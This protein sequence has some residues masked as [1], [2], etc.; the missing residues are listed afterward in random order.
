MNRRVSRKRVIQ[1]NEE[2]LLN[3]CEAHLHFLVDATR[4]Y[5]EG[6][7]HRFK[8]IAAELRVLVA[9]RKRPI[10]LSR[11][12]HYGFAYEVQPHKAPPLNSMP[13]AMKGDI[14]SAPSIY[15]PDEKIDDDLLKR[16]MDEQAAKVHAIPL[17][18]FVKRGLAVYSRP[19]EYSYQDLVLELAQRLGSSHEDITFDEQITVL[20]PIS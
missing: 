19:H 14:R 11:M 10:L 9:D 2:H 5:H 7:Q 6:Q 3:D 13:I 12:E 8:Q 15:E 4:L 16:A 1:K 17:R 20:T 18:Q